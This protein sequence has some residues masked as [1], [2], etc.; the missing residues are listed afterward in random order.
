MT[1]PD[2]PTLEAVEVLPGHAARQTATKKPLSLIWKK[3][4]SGLPHVV[5]VEALPG[6]AARLTLADGQAVEVED[7]ADSF[8]SPEEYA[9]VLLCVENGQAEGLYVLPDALRFAVM[10]ALGY[11]PPTSAAP[12]TVEGVTLE[13]PGRAALSLRLAD[14]QPFA[15]RLP[16]PVPYALSGR[17]SEA[18]RGQP[19]TLTLWQGQPRAFTAFVPFQ[20]WPQLCPVL[21]EEGGKA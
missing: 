14:G 15:Y 3:D 4:P 11:A 6:G 8:I 13:G 12:P 2:V 16:V 9:P 18:R 20:V 7:A 17:R 10:G 21:S 1:G 5:S 19:Y